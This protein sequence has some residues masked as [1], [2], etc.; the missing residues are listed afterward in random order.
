MLNMWHWNLITQEKA[1]E[2]SEG[3]LKDILM[4]GEISINDDLEMFLTNL[5]NSKEIKKEGVVS[6]L[7]PKLTKEELK[8]VEEKN[9]DHLENYWAHFKGYPQTLR[10]Q[11]LSVNLKKTLH[12]HKITLH[13]YKITLHILKKTL[14][15]FKKTLHFLKITLHFLKKSLN[16]LKKTLSFPEKFSRFEIF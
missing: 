9:K 10:D 12:F 13:F 14:H 16:Y 7:T 5:L 8:L 2:A 3:K 15:F 1:K 6:F 11:K 4:W